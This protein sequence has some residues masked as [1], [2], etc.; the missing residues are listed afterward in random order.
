MKPK[1]LG[2]LV[3][4]PAL[5]SQAAERAT[6][7]QLEVMVAKAA[8][9]KEGDWQP[10]EVKPYPKKRPD[11]TEMVMMRWT[12]REGVKVLSATDGTSPHPRPDVW[13]EISLH[14][15][16]EKATEDLHEAVRF[17]ASSIGPKGVVKHLGD[18]AFLW[19]S[20]PH[21]SALIKVRVRRA[22]IEVAGPSLDVTMRFAEL[23]VREVES[24]FKQA[25][26]SP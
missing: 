14:G 13:V 10:K 4:L 15:S 2:L 5:S 9:G 23:A 17:G 6:T 26:E 3:L 20:S 12:P 22:G 11:G 7:K 24:E 16:P 21:G 1:L 19:S 25:G 8:A 18:E